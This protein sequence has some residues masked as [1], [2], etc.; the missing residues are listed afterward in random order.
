MPGNVIHLPRGNPHQLEALTD[1]IVIEVS[2]P[3][4]PAD[5][6]RIGKGSSQE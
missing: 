5:N 1:S 4:N 6:Y 3:D 2:T